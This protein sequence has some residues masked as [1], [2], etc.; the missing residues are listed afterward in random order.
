MDIRSSTGFALPSVIIA[1]VVMFIVLLASLTSVTSSSIALERL[2]LDKLSKEAQQSGLSMAAVCLNANDGAPL[3]T[4]GKP[5]RPNTDCTGTDVVSCANN[6]SDSSRCYINKVDGYNVRYAVTYTTDSAGS[7]LEIRSNAIVEKVSKTT[8]SPVE[9]FQQ[10][11]KSQLSVTFSAASEPIVSTIAGTGSAGF[12]DGQGSSARFNNP[13]AVAA[14]GSG[15]IYVAD[16]LNHRIRK[17]DTSTTQNNVTTIAG[18]G[19]IGSTDGPGSSARFNYPS[20]ITVD[21]SG[22][23]YVADLRNNRI[24][25]IDTSTTQYNVT[26][27]AGTGSTGN[28]DGPGSSA[29]FNFPIGIALD[30][31]NNLF[32]TDYYNNSVRKIDTSTTQYNVTTVAGSGSTGTTDGPGSSARFNRPY[33]LAVKNSDIYVAD[34]ENNSIRKIDISTTQNNVTTIAGSTSAGNIEGAGLSARFN[35]PSGIAIDKVGN[36]YVTDSRNHSVRKMDTSTAQNNVTTI[37]GTGSAGTTDGPGSSAQFNTP[38]RLTLEP[39]SGN[40]Y[41]PDYGNNRIRKIEFLKSS[42]LAPVISY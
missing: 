41:V 29:R 36:V 32:V 2:Y 9:R 34:Y 17:I 25:K 39:I 30:G 19:S 22:N 1:S 20:G 28:I 11:G 8:G 5:L 24:R 18:T 16:Y 3:W 33:G 31:S 4:N 37:A 26:T 12:T 6:N 7:L 14:D 15:N 27:I 35:G 21:G 38:S 10:A 42:P 13:V 23:V 40:M